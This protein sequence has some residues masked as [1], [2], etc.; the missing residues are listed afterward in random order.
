MLSTV[1]E[2]PFLSMASNPSRQATLSTIVNY[3]IDTTAKS[4]G[5]R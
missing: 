3:F 4:I 1:R 2:K 5:G